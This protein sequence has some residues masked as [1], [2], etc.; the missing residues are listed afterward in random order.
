MLKLVKL[1][2]GTDHTSK[3]VSGRFLML[4]QP[5]GP[6][7]TSE[8][9]SGR[10]LIGRQKGPDQ[11]S[12]MVRGRILMLGLSKGADHTYKISKEIAVILG[13]PKLVDDIFEILRLPNS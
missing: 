10:C 1:L 7:H 11:T 3:M 2:R 8:M 6:D 12:K 9:D 4:G 5:K 13:R